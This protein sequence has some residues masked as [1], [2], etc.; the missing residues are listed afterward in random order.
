V[1]GARAPP[2]QQDRRE[3]ARDVLERE[4]QRRAEGGQRGEVGQQ[5]DRRDGAGR[6]PEQQQ[7]PQTDAGKPHQR[8]RG[9][10]VPDEGRD[11]VDAHDG[12]EDVAD[13]P[14][15]HERQADAQAHQPRQ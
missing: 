15:A 9:E 7:E 10:R 8:V 6:Q 5:A 12:R 1:I 3:K 2:A 14:R 11:R 13:E 4:Q